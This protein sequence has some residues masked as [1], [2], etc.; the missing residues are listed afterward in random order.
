M[1]EISVKLEVDGDNH[2]PVKLSA[3]KPTDGTYHWKTVLLSVVVSIHCDITFTDIMFQFTQF[4][5]TEHNHIQILV[6][7]KES[8][9]PVSHFSL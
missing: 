5:Q 2:F 7:R 8:F 3:T 1:R 6:W 4:I 9:S